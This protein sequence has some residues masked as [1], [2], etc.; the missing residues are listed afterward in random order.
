M[1]RAQGSVDDQGI[2]TS[3]SEHLEEAHV[4]MQVVENAKD[5]RCFHLQFGVPHHLINRTHVETETR[6]RYAIGEEIVLSSRDKL[7]SWFD[8]YHMCRAAAQRGKCPST[9]MASDIENTL[10][11]DPSPMAINQRF[12]PCV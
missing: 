6:W 12:V 8:A 2:G 4:V 3:A 1:V 10:S 7:R 5:E 9:I 11:C